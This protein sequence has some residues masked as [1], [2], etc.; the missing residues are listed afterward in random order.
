MVEGE[1]YPNSKATEKIHRFRQVEDNLENK[2]RNRKRE[3]HMLSFCVKA[4]VLSMI[5]KIK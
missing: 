1:K 3:F 4:S 5:F 2:A